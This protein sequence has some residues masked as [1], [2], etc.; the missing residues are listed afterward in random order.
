M[1]YI[2]RHGVMRFL[3]EFEPAPGHAYAR[4]Q[5]VVVRTE[6]GQETADVLCESSPR[7]LEMLTE[8]TKGQI[9]RV[10][11]EE[12]HALARTTREREHAEFLRCQE[13]IRERKLQMD[14]VDVEHLFGGER[15]VFFFLAE[16]RVD[17]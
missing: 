17:F 10:M 13:F 14:L 11:T 7:A 8:P 15:V 5:Q 2:V 6:R 16:K 4:G 3:G 1:H 9:L 12:D